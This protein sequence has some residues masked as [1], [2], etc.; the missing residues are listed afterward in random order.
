MSFYKQLL[1]NLPR[2]KTKLTL[3]MKNNSIPETKVRY[4]IE[5]IKKGIY[6]KTIRKHINPKANHLYKDHS[7]SLI[8]CKIN[9]DSKRCS[10]KGTL[11]PNLCKR[12]QSS[13]RCAKLKVKTLKNKK[14]N[15]DINVIIY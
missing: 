3:Y 14:Q 5:G 8:Q 6:E 2:K 1:E 9:S 15:I 12:N 7:Y 13:K 11:T 10:Q 4:L